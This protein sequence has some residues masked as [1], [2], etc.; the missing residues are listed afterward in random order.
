MSATFDD[1]YHRIDE[2]VENDDHRLP[3]ELRQET[4]DAL[5]E[6]DVQILEEMPG[7]GGGRR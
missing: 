3:D 7:N 1:A 6:R 4:W 5:D 2:L